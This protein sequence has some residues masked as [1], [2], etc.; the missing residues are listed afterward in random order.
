MTVLTDVMLFL[1]LGLLVRSSRQI[2]L[3]QVTFAAI[4]AV[5]FSKLAGAGVPWLPALLIAGLVVVPIGALLAIPAVRLS[6]LY[7]ALATF[8]F[9]LLV[10]AMFYQSSI[11]FGI[12]DLGLPMPRPDTELAA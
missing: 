12:E 5:A 7:L 6:G 8:G 1:S 9:G 2:S 11:G 4:G 10:Q 3:C